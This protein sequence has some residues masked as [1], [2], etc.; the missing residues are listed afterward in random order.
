MVSTPPVPPDGRADD[1]DPTGIRA[2]LSVLPDPGPMP[3]DLVDR[4]N[5][6]IAAEQPGRED[7]HRRP[8]PAAALGL[9]APRAAAAAAPSSPSASRRCSP[10]PAR[11]TWWP[12]SGRQATR[13]TA[14]AGPRPASRAASDSGA[15][16]RHSARPTP[17]PAAQRVAAGVGDVAL[18]AS[19]TAY[20]VAGLATQA[21]AA[22]RS[23]ARTTRPPGT[24]ALGRGQPTTAPGCAAASPPLGVRPRCRVRGRRRDPR[25]RPRG[26]RRRQQRHRTDRVCRVARLRRR[27]PRRAGRPAPRALSARARGPRVDRRRPARRGRRAVAGTSRPYDR[28]QITGTV[29]SG[30][31]PSRPQGAV[32]A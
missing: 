4:I 8:P 6:S 25:R 16:R 29:C 23:D 14:P 2:L 19:G 22:P 13:P 10:A 24:Q 31:P 7:P 9:A 3:A 20:T 1:L 21:R 15:G 18:V 26:D 27:P 12:R 17:A 32:T 28:L 30:A 5:A 11:A